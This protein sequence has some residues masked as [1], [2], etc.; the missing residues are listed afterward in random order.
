[1]TKKVVALYPGTFDPVTY[2]HIDVIERASQFFEK[3]IVTVAI[4]PN[5]IPLFSEEER[6]DMLIRSVKRFPN[7]EVDVF[8]GLVVD[9]AR[10][11]KASVVIR[12]LRAVSDFEYEFQMSLTNRKL[13]PEISTIFMMPNEK[14]TYLN[15][16]LVRELI[17]YGAN[18]SDFVPPYVIRLYKKKIN[19]KK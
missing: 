17:Y 15:S 3:L 6:K 5:K 10:L 12:G 7:V 4:N 2:G 16:S 8:K 14:Y 13:A 18:V 19:K 11:K 9:Y 1:M